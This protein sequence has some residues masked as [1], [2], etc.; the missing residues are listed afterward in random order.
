LEL[1]V[2][3]ITRTGIRYCRARPAPLLD[4]DPSF[5]FNKNLPGFS[6]LLFERPRQAAPPTTRERTCNSGRGRMRPIGAGRRP[7][8][9]MHLRRDT[10]GEHGLGVN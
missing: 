2:V 4:I 7:N 1:P 10:G 6:F 8:H 5:T 9:R 3:E